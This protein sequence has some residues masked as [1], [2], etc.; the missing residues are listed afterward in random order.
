MFIVLQKDSSVADRFF[1][2][3]NDYVTINSA[4]LEEAIKHAEEL[5]KDTKTHCVI[6][7]AVK[8]IEVVHSTK[9]VDL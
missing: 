3:D 4:T 8:E 2:N 6:F 1:A 9:V 5:S 7:K